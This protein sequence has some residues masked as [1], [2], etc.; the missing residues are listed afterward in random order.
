MTTLNQTRFTT[1]LAAIILSFSTLIAS[2]AFAVGGGGGN[3]QL[4]L[5]AG[6]INADQEHMNT[7]ISRANTREGGISTGSLNNA[8]EAAGTFGYRFNGSIIALL[9]R[10]SFFY[11]KS[12]G[13]GSSGN[14]NYSNIGFTI[15]PIGRIYPLEN[16]FM[17]FFMQF[18]LGY[19][20]SNG[21]IEEGSAKAEF[22]GDA[23]GTVFGLGSEFCY[24]GTHCLVVE[25][26][27]RYLTIERNIATS[28]TGT[29][30]STSPASL[31]QAE[32]HKEIEMDS[33]DLHVKMSGLQFLLGYSFYF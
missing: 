27:Y 24:A 23:F 31:S 30:S 26:N 8:Y 17:K 4:G 9:F 33:T 20:R 1:F 32:I 13:T 28:V 12:E 3:F 21:S 7:L 2:P 5:S 6:T 29:F 18:G 16:E 19:G 11:Q 14:F 10:P 25:G 22:V 15:F